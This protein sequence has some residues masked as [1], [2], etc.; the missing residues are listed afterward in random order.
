MMDK[1]G[2]SGNP[3]VSVRPML[4]AEEIDPILSFVDQ[5]VPSG[6]TAVWLTGSRAK[7]LARPDSDWDVVAFHPAAL[8][9]PEDLFQSNQL[10]PHPLG[11]QIELVI[12]HPDHWND[13]R[14]Y[15]SDLRA[16]GIRLR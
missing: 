11:G 16:Q 6:C 3:R 15:M 8:R 13:P 7:G 4:T 9:Q 10:G 5:F 14:Q 1:P 12:A 2:A